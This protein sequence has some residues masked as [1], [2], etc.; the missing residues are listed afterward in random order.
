M[1]E[2]VMCKNHVNFSRE[3]V[4]KVNDLFHVWQHNVWAR[5]IF[6]HYRGISTHTVLSLLFAVALTATSGFFVLLSCTSY[7]CWFFVKKLETENGCLYLLGIVYIYRV[8]IYTTCDYQ[9]VL[10]MIYYVSLWCYD[11]QWCWF[12]HVM[13]TIKI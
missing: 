2:I 13:R 5:P 12:L 7:S 8:D 9:I 1:V 6:S 11:I 10:R 3:A 4:L